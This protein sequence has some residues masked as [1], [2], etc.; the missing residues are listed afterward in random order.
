[1]R[2]REPE[3]R[4][5][6]GRPWLARQLPAT[7]PPSPRRCPWP[8]PSPQPRGPPP[9]PPPPPPPSTPPPP[10]ARAGA[11]GQPLR[12]GR[13][14]LRAPRRARRH[15]R[16]PVDARRLDARLRGERPPEPVVGN[17]Q[18]QVAAPRG[19]E[20]LRGHVVRVRA[21]RQ[22]LRLGAVVQPGGR[23]VVELGQHHLAH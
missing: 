4:A 3:R 13:G 8:P 23:P 22:P 9:P 19:R 14:A 16:E 7:S 11:R 21:E 5:G 20:Q 2:P 12:Q 6:S 15:R 10:Q 17:E 1:M 18:R